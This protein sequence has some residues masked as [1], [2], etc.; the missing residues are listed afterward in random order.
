MTA[1]IRKWFCCKK[2]SSIVSLPFLH[3]NNFYDSTIVAHYCSGWGYSVCELHPTIQ[4][5]AEI[6]CLTSLIGLKQSRLKKDSSSSL[7][8]PA[9]QIVIV[10]TV[11]RPSFIGEIC[12]HYLAVPTCRVGDL[13]TCRVEHLSRNNSSTRSFVRISNLMVFLISPRSVENCCLSKIS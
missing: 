3:L 11:W 6:S 9:Q 4:V 12:F 10:E 13:P 2:L 7:Q 5:A 1:F 8:R